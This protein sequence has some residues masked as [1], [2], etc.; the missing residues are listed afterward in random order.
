MTRRANRPALGDA[1]IKRRNWRPARTAHLALTAWL[2]LVASAVA[3]LR[4][5]HHFGDRQLEGRNLGQTDLADIDQDGDLDFLV[6]EQTRK[7]SMT[8]CASARIAGLSRIGRGQGVR[9]LHSAHPMASFACDAMEG[10]SVIPFRY[11]ARRSDRASSILPGPTSGRSRS[12]MT[13]DCVATKPI[14]ARTT[15]G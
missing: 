11:E 7:G 6:G 14:S 1:A 12:V 5:V 13:F 2:V 8:S 9:S 3:E 4:F 15:C 10:C